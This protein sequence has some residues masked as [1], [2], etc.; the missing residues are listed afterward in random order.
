MRIQ[1]LKAAHEQGQPVLRSKQGSKE[2]LLPLARAQ[3]V[4][5]IQQNGRLEK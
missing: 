3:K 2:D 4:V 1:N 5:T